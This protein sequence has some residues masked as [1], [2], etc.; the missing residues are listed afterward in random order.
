METHKLFW[1]QNN[2]E[3]DVFIFKKE[4]V[5]LVSVGHWK[6]PKMMSQILRVY[7]QPI[8]GVHEHLYVQLS[9]SVGVYRLKSFN[10]F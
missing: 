6:T 10:T 1:Q 3:D 8:R 2:N 5:S 7:T 9:R 4:T